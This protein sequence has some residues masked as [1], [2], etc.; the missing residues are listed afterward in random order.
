M[1]RLEFFSRRG[2]APGVLSLSVLVG[3]WSCATG[4]D[5]SDAE[6]AEICAGGDVI[7]PNEGGSSGVS[8]SGTTAGSGGSG[9]ISQGNSG[10]GGGNSSGGSSNSTSTGGTAPVNGGAGNSSGGSAAGSGPI[11]QGGTCSAAVAPVAAGGCAAAGMIQVTYTDRSN[12]ADFNQLTM[13]LNLTNSGTDFSLDDLILRYWFTPDGQTSFIAEIDYAQVGKENVCVNFG[14][15]RGQ[16][17]AD[18]GFTTNAMAGGAV[19]DVQLRVHTQNYSPLSQADDFSYMGDAENVAN[20]NVT[21]YLS[22][23]RVAGCEPP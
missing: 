6:L 2:A 10:T 5:V 22:G 7:C 12:A 21:V 17:F 13:T 20:Q 3:L 14:N 16:S 15:Q 1:N 19:R 23:A 9:S 18:I 11:T 8:G 4:V